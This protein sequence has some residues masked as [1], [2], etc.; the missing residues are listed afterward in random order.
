VPS[1][2]AYSPEPNILERRFAAYLKRHDAEHGTEDHPDEVRVQKIR[3]VTWISIALAGLAGII[4]GGLIGGA[5]IWMRQGI[6]NGD[7]NMGWRETWPYWTGFYAFVGVV[8]A[9]E[10]GALYALTMSGLARITRHS[11][12]TLS[13]GGDRGLLAH[14]L[15][16]AGLEFPNPQVRICGI[17]PYAKVSNWRLTA[18]NVAYRMKV[19]VSS[20]VFR[21]FLRRVAARMAIR[22][23]VPLYAGPLF[24]AWNVFIVWRIMT[25]SRVRTLGPFVVDTLIKRHFQDTDELD[26]T[27]TD[28]ALHAAGEMLVRG[29][30]A[31]PNQVY[32]MK[33]LCNAL[34]QGQD[35]TLDW[36]GMRGQLSGLEP[37]AQDR[38]LDLMTVSCLIGAR[39]RREQRELLRQACGD[40]G[41]DLNDRRLDALRR[42]M[43]RGHHVSGDDIAAT[44]S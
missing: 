25:E 9:V 43:K 22:G 14:S 19:G 34:G 21:V 37:A 23:F 13:D 18:L 28:V 38:V 1:A 2:D 39:L 16:R 7:E 17:D 35:I 10:I 4:S 3:R 26:Q 11:G 44:R 6:L 30:D 29:R 8:S 24:A 41:A 27:G 33:R 5:E 12:L 42:A 31:H 36:D 20:F 15:A 40:C 32:L